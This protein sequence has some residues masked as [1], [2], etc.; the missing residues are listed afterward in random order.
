MAAMNTDANIS[1]HILKSVYNYLVCDKYHISKKRM[2]TKCTEKTTYL[3][4]KRLSKPFILCQ[5]SKRNSRWIK[6]I[7]CLKRDLTNSRR[8]LDSCIILVFEKP[9]LQITPKA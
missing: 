4:G 2:I 5:I 3:S 7:K 9:V 6:E 1:F 8:N